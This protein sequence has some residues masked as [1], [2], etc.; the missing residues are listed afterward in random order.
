MD[1]LQSWEGFGSI[2]HDVKYV[3]SDQRLPSDIWLA[4]GYTGVQIYEKNQSKAIR[5]IPYEEIESFGGP[6]LNKFK[7]VVVGEDAMLFETNKVNELAKLI[8]SYL[9]LVMVQ[10]RG[11]VSSTV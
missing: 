6:Y 1:I 10:R 3:L 9:S 4:I 2:I 11:S 8:K 7:L 5:I